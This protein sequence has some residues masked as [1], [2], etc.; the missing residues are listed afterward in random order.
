MRSIVRA[1]LF[2]VL[3]LAIAGGVTWGFYANRGEQAADSDDAPVQAPSRVSS[4]EGRSVLSFDEDAQKANGIRT[5]VLSASSQR[6]R[7][8]ATG[9]VVQLQPLLDLKASYNAPRTEL[10]R[11]NA[12]ARASAQEYRRLKQLNEEDKDASDKSVEAARAASEND[13]A[14]VQN[15]QQAITIL[16]ANALLHWGGVVT[17]WMERDS[18]EFEALLKQQRFLLQVT[19]TAGGGLA[20]PGEATVELPD[21]THTVARFVSPV[22]QLDSRLQTPSALYVISAHPGLVAG[23]NLSVFLPA[24]AVQTGVVLPSSAVV[25][26]QGNAWCFVETTPGKFSRIAVDTS[27]PASNGWFVTKE[28]TPGM[29]VVTAGA[30]TLLS[31]EFRSQIQ[32]DAD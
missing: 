26:S 4:Q 12:N 16:H 30:Q 28:I 22:P 32:A 3:V 27:N 5:M 17:G 1:V 6:S 2:G 25:W 24:Q 18:A 13:A 20:L 21:G 29:R 10:L 8:P 31:E 23:M 19:S 7:T 14:L 15:A 9:V 11:T